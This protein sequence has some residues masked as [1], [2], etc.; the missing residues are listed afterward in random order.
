MT[1]VASLTELTVESFVGV[2]MI[3]SLQATLGEVEVVEVPGNAF[4]IVGVLMEGKESKKEGNVKGEKEGTK[5]GKRPG[6][7][8]EFVG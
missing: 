5:G 3:V 6:K 8:G 2:P 7:R 4:P 1:T